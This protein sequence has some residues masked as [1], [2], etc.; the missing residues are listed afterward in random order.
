MHCLTSII[1]KPLYSG[2]LFRS[3]TNTL[4]YCLTSIIRK[5]LYSGHLI[6]SHTN[7]LV[8]CLTSI[9]RKPLYSG[10]LF[11]SHTLVYCLTSIIRKPLIIIIWDLYL[12]IILIYYAQVQLHTLF[13]QYQDLASSCSEVARDRMKLKGDIQLLRDEL[14]RLVSRR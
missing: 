4:V 3:H 14:H 13:Q 8:H 12:C 9:I 6:Q 11:R 5:P 1:R 7:T 2:H 10:H